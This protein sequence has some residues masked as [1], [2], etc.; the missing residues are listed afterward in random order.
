M[1]ETKTY[2]LPKTFPSDHWDRDCG[3]TD[4]IVRETKSHFFVE[5]DG[6]GYSDMESDAEYYRDCGSEMGWE[7]QGL[8]SSAR[9]TL[10]ALK[11]AG[12]PWAE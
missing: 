2:R 10:A 1:S 6:D 4:K 7:Y 5:M 3:R 9:A 11:K 12:P 8:I